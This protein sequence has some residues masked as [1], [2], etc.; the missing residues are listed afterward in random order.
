MRS[1]C[2]PR[3]ATDRPASSRISFWLAFCT[4]SVS[5]Q[6]CTPD[7]DRANLV[8]A[9]LGHARLARVSLIGAQLHGASLLGAD[10]RDA[11]LMDGDMR[12][13]DLHAS[14]LRR[15]NFSRAFSRSGR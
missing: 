3:W 9:D 15:A 7:L 14:D 4:V 12:N 13:A 5:G 1:G 6:G 8:G 11:I 2:I 10:L